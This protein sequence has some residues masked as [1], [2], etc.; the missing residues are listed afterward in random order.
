MKI[1]RYPISKPQ[2]VELT[3]PKQPTPREREKS[4]QWK[5]YTKDN[6]NEHHFQQKGRIR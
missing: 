4:G 5:F 6:C 3:I 2:S 1:T